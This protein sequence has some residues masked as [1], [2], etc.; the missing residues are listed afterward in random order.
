VF[1]AYIDK[2]SNLKAEFTAIID[3][4]RENLQEAIELILDD[5]REDLTRGL[6]PSVIRSTLLIE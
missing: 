6:P 5:R 2:G 3:E 1:Q 4:T